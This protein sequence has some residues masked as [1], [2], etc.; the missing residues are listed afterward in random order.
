MPG[1]FVAYPDFL[2]HGI[3]LSKINVMALPSIAFNKANES[4]SFSSEKSFAKPT[5]HTTSKL[6]RPH[7][8]KAFAVLEGESMLQI[9]VA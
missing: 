5:L 4:S 1:T 9:E 6:K 8:S 2:S 3:A 7:K